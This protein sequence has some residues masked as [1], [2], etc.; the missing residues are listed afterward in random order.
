MQKLVYKTWIS[1]DQRSFEWKMKLKS[2]RRDLHSF[3][4]V[5]DT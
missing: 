4:F 5:R 1:Y 3:L 2:L